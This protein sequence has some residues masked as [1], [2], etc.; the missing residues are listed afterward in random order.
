MVLA[1]TLNIYNM[2]LINLPTMVSCF[3]S[4]AFQIGM[5]Y[6]PIHIMNILQRNYDKLENKKFLAMYNTIISELDLSH[7][8]K[9]MFYSMYFLRR[10]IFTFLIVLFGASPVMEVATQGS[11]SFFFILYVLIAKPFK[12]KVTSFM[13][14][15]GELILMALYGIGMAINDPNQPDLVNQKFGFLV[16]GIFSLLLLMGGLV[17][18]I[19]VTQDI[20]EECK[21]RANKDHD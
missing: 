6:L 19:Q 7:P 11:A 2:E 9:Y 10:I 20:R 21:R 3:V 17:I 18:I 1:A 8:S 5:I 13:T 16:V 4:I 12:R 15:F 14:I